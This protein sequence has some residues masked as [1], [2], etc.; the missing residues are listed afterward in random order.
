[1]K[2]VIILLMLMVCIGANQSFGQEYKVKATG[3]KTLKIL[4]V[5]KVELVGSTGSEIV[6]STEIKKDR[7]EERA[8]GLTAI[9]G[10]GL[11]DNSGI[12][13]SIIEKGSI[14]EVQQLAKR[15]SN[16]YVIQ[17]PANVK[18]FYEHSS[19]EGSSF[20][21]KDIKSELEVSTLH[22]NVLLDNITGPMTINSVHGKVEVIFSSLDQ[23]NPTSILSVH[24]L[25]DVTLPATT[26]ANLKMES[27]W[28]E[29]Y[30]D[31]NIEFDKSEGDLK[32]YS[33]KVNGKLNGG[34]IELHLASTHNNVYLRTK[35]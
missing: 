1:M 34:G 17:V 13:L 10:L 3:D 27:N 24:G 21:A 23:Q 26:K 19:V 30:T 31:M 33:S 20:K 22:N 28:G 6:L 4:G 8:K 7:D 25:V 35:K 16:K 11:T 32:Q 2:K 12:G 14:I 5:N 9:S 15:N 29:L 18:I